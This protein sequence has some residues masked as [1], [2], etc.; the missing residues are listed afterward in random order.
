MTDPHAP[1]PPP[2]RAAATGGTRATLP[3]TLL[4]QMG[5]S[6]A[7]LAPTVAAPRL[8]AELGLGTVAVGLYIAVV[9]LGATISSQ[10]GAA[11]IKRWGPIRTS[12]VCLLSCAI[13]LLLVS[14]PQV[15]AAALGALLI[16]AGYGPI[17][18]ASSEILARTTPP[19]RYSLVFSVKQTGVPAGGALAG[20]LVPTV[21]LWGGSIAALGQIAVLC[22]AALLLAQPLRALLDGLRDPHAPLPTL[23]R[24]TDP[25][26]FV[27]A[28][29]VLRKL[30]FCSFVFS[31][32]QVCLTSYLVSFLKADLLWTLVAAGVALSAAQ[33][34]GVVGRIAW[35]VV[36]DRRRDARGTL[37][38]LAVAMAVA[39]ICM[40]LLGPNTPTA[41]VTAL[42]VVF[43]ATAVGWNGVFLATVARVAPSSAA[44]ATA[45]SLFFTYFGVVIGPPIF[46]AIGGQ[47]GAL[48]GAYA[49]LALPLAWTIWVL[50]RADWA[51]DGTP[52]RAER[53]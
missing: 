20:L 28:D 5:A 23:A 11:L 43:G 25:I 45:G 24:I 38:G 52:G 8:L 10:A 36:A 4:I 49:L 7:S 18:P 2:A 50:A 46:G 14:V 51:V 22:I 40:S 34:A 30:G 17:T 6:A 27:L 42:L 47:L 29:P 41:W 3:I 31:A 12:Q 16:G 1:P 53:R 9:Y 44:V 15:W 32:V 35:G 21:L 33:V 26:R 19:E 13:G 39:A 48:G 37:L